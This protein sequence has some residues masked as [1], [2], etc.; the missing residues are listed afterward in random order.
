MTAVNE[1]LT[2]V[3]LSRLAAELGT[4]EQTARS[5]A[6]TAAAELLGGLASNAQDPNGEVSLAGAL[7]DHADN[8]HLIDAGTADL[9]QVDQADAAKIL[10][11]VFGDT[12]AVALAAAQRAAGGNVDQDMMMKALKFLAPIV[13][14]YLAKNLQGGKYG[15]IL[16]GILGGGAGGSQSAGGGILGQILGGVLGGG[17]GGALG[18]GGLGGQPET[19]APHQQ[20]PSNPFDRPDSGDG[21]LRMDDGTGDARYQEQVRADQQQQPQ[22]GGIFGDI[23]GKIF[24]R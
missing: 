24:G 22:S 18:G 16:G 13:L 3:P 7:R 20:A 21:G 8:N 1:I 10:G 9:G 11:H 5:A 12:D 17:L 6:E 2:H 19:R 4:D 23:L 15:D 14:A